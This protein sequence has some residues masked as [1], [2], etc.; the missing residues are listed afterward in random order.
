[1]FID[2]MTD[3]FAENENADAIVWRDRTYT[4]NWLLERMESWRE[5][6]Q[7]EGIVSGKVVVL[8]A[9]FSPNSISLFLV[10]A[11]AGCIVVPLTSAVEAKKKEFVRI[12]EGYCWRLSKLYRNSTSLTKQSSILESC[13][14]CS[15]AIRWRRCRSS[16]CLWKL[17]PRA[18]TSPRRF[19]N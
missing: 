5:R 17:A 15:P 19:S 9:D 16:S 8:E 11:E 7:A 6:V 2:F 13:Y 14:N 4:Y 12:A 1:M 10:L 3:V 18:G